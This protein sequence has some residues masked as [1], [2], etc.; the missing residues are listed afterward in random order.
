MF[1][2]KWDKKGTVMKNRKFKVVRKEY[3]EMET[4][5]EAPTADKAEEII[6]NKLEGTDIDSVMEKENAF[7]VDF[8]VTLL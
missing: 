3:W 4:I 2:Y 6:M 5:I 8:V 1:L 7:S